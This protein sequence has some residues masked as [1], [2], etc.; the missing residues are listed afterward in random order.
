MC[1]G[2]PSSTPQ[3]LK[4]PVFAGVQDLL[5]RADVVFSPQLSTTQADFRLLALAPELEALLKAGQ[6]CDNLNKSHKS[7]KKH[8]HKSHKKD[9]KHKDKSKDKDRDG[10]RAR[11]DKDRD[12][13]N[14]GPR[15]LVNAP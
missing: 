3:A 4:N 8:K 6:R 11:H 9:D 12:T 5:K 13:G 2:V 14:A 1:G 7:S 10:K 15:R